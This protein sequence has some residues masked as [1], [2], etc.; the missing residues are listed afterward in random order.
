MKGEETMKTRIQPV[1]VVSE[2]AMED[3][4]DLQFKAHEAL[5]EAL[6]E[7]AFA[8]HMN[9]LDILPPDFVCGVCGDE[10]YWEPRHEHYYGINIFDR[11][12]GEKIEVCNE[13]FEKLDKSVYVAESASTV[14]EALKLEKERKRKAEVF[15][16]AMDTLRSKGYTDGEFADLLDAAR[17]I[18]RDWLNGACGLS[19]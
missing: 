9:A 6:N 16:K 18:N 11:T 4:L 19:A 15:Q 1:F 3:H 13:C 2:E 5:L 12:T 10:E 14:E 17:H 7:E 8:E